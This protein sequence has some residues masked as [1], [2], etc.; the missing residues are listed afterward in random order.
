MLAC[1]ETREGGLQL[2]G[3]AGGLA[4]TP[5]HSEA[6]FTLE[7]P[8]GDFSLHFKDERPLERSTQGGR[9]SG[10][11]WGPGVSSGATWEALWHR[12]KLE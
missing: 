3:R 10:P 1:G 12:W 5:V 9:V 7:T 2:V 6:P 11:V 4:P 8:S